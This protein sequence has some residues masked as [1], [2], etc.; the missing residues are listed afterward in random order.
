MKIDAAIRESYERQARIARQLK[1]EVDIDLQKR[2]H[3]SWHYESRV[4]GDES[5]A[6]KVE[7]G[8]VPDPNR[9]EDVFG[10][11]LVVPNATRLPEAEAVVTQRYSVHERRPPT[12]TG[13]TKRP[14]D[15]LF[16]DV[17]LYVRYE[18]TEGE[19]TAIPDGTLFEVQIKTFL[20]HAWAVATHDLIYKSEQRDWRRERVAYQ[21]RATLE[22]AEVTIAGIEALAA[23]DVLP[24]AN[25]EIDQLNEII[26]VLNTEWDAAALPR[27]VRSLAESVN[28]LL[29]IVDGSPAADRVE[30]LRALLLSGSQRNAGAHSLD[31]S[32]YR[33][34]LNYIADDHS[35]RLSRRLRNGGQSQKAKVLV[36]PET[37][38][39]LGIEQ[40]EA[41][42]AVVLP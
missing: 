31:W 15:F 11:T 33:S 23:S 21:V 10:A 29:K 20:Q 24:S 30:I 13:T 9:M 26:D 3:S 1:G 40:A 18:R 38:A 28:N 4:K 39:R 42:G 25:P 7:S 41:R 16:D 37:L 6:I 27:N 8:R 5:F 36:Y 19:R 12:A 34:V 22:Q 35:Q 14:H 2:K 17:R 32:P